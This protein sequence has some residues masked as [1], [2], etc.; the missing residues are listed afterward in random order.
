MHAL[1]LGGTREA[2]DLAPLLLERGWRVTSSLAGRVRDPAL[3]AGE[4]RIGG[5]GGPQGLADWIARH[6]VDVIVDA[7]HPF[8]ERISASAAAAAGETPLI[9]L[10]RPAWQA[11]DEWTM[12]ASMEDAAAACGESGRRIFLT[13]GR[14]NLHVFADSGNDF[15]I[16]CVE[17]P[18]EPLP[19]RRLILLSRGP[20]TVEGEIT[21]MR[22]HRIDALVTKNSGGTL[23]AAKLEAA[24]ELGVE[25][26]MIERPG[27]P[28][29]DLVVHS[30][31]EA[32]NR[33]CSAVR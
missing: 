24:R 12:V 2:R 13:I 31:E 19:E 22:E 10:H 15:L 30:A 25:V 32:L 33:C 8:A 1:I 23:T 27:L 21:L 5:F 4:V 26:I 11:E 20:F 17:Q 18:V 3:P 29:V 14:Q 28:E 7:T 9:A 6:C 16:R